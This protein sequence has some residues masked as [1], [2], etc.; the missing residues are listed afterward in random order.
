MAQ[1]LRVARALQVARELQ[2][3]QALRVVR[4]LQVAQALRAVQAQA[5]RVR[6]APE[7]LRPLAELLV[8][9]PRA[10]R[11]VI[12]RRCAARSR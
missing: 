5:V 7:A 6:Q 8:L 2:A 1:E 3:A 11:A 12:S 9:A 10:E 4:A